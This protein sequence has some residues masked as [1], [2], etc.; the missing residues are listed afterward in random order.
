MYVRREFNAEE[1]ELSG[2][3]RK[4]LVAVEELLDRLPNCRE[5]ALH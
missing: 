2:E 3:I 5:K 1:I 4:G